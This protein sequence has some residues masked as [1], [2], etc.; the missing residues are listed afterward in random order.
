MSRVSIAGRLY[1]FVPICLVAAALTL[2]YALFQ[3]HDRML[4]D[5]EDMTRQLVQTASG[6][7]ADWQARE[8]A[9]LVTREQAQKGAHDQLIHL[10][11]GADGYFFVFS[12]TGEAIVY[13]NRSME[14]QNQIDLADARGFHQ[15]RRFI[16]VA[17]TGGGFVS[18]HWAHAGNG[19]VAEKISFV[20]PD[21]RW[22]WVLGTGLYVDDVDAVFWH[23]LRVSLMVTAGLMLPVLLAALVISRSIR[24]PLGQITDRMGRL[25]NGDLSVDVPFLKDRNEMGRLARAL[26][27]FKV[28]RARAEE[29]GRMQQEE[30]SE[31][32]RRQE[33]VDQLIG[34]FAGRSA[35]VLAAMVGAATQVQDHAGQLARMAEASL[36]RVAGANR[37]ASDTEGNV[38]TIA[39]A[40]E[41]LSA[42]VSEVSRQVTQSSRVAERAVGEADQTNIAMTAL[43]G[44]AQRIGT[45]V[46]VIQD[47]ASQTN[48]LALNATIEAARAGN[49]GKGFAVVAGEVKT[50]AGQTTRATEEIQA[51]VVGIQSETTDAVA[52]LQGIVRTVADMSAISAAIASAMAQQGATTREIAVNIG[53]A[54]AG[55]KAV[56]EH[57]DGVADAAAS[58]NQAAAELFGASDALHREADAL[59]TELTAFFEQLRAA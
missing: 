43:A 2:L 18:Y 57:V 55:T 17:K 36:D 24:G 20:Q 12:E 13:A 28:N 23:E 1:L 26:E 54:A 38:A 49:A 45:I 29:L 51:Q 16:E 47:I 15:V 27:V 11:F 48:L 25:A 39:G 32:L 40:A 10:K 3:L 9:G 7:I 8:D 53:G 52:A 30:Q 58:T 35:E 5:R 22:G 41:Q 6:V 19:K 21:G 44:A 37:A 46:T 59:N 50:L 34:N 31:K 14:G 42:A 56:S 33:R 4:A